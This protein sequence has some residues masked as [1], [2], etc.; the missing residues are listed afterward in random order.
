MKSIR[1]QMRH[2][3]L[4]LFIG[5]VGFRC[6]DPTGTSDETSDETSDKPKIF[7]VGV[8]NN[9]EIFSM[10][11]DGSEKTQITS[12]STNDYEPQFSPDGTKLYFQALSSQDI[13]LAYVDIN[14]GAEQLITSI[15]ADNYFQWN[16]SYSCYNDHVVYSQL[17][18]DETNLYRSNLDGSSIAQLTNNFYSITPTVSPDG[19][20]I[21]YS[22]NGITVMDSDGTNARKVS[23][24]NIEGQGPIRFTSDGESIVFPARSGGNDSEIYRVNIDST[25]LVQ[26]TDNDVTDT[27]PAISPDGTR[28]IFIRVPA[29]GWDLGDIYIM[30][31]DGS[32]QTM[33][34]TGAQV[35]VDEGLEFS[36]DGTKIV[37]TS[38]E[39]SAG[40]GRIFIMNVDGSEQTRLTAGPYQSM[41][42]RFQP[43]EN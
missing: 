42:P 12:N 2:L 24:H 10:N 32:N 38:E 8:G 34:S 27:V 29:E 13:Y 5:L 40:S 4:S 9:F 35:R 36:P 3:V 11:Y 30:D 26:L 20:Q 43:T 23:I 6:E 18:G 25:G 22:S 37:Y 16:P 21:A 1:F 19:T 28:I 31:A 33:L 7:Y 14:T 17:R 15:K 41:Y 39:E